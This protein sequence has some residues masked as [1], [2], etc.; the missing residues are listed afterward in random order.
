MNRDIW[1]ATGVAHSL[2]AASMAGPS[3]RRGFKASS[4]AVGRR[5]FASSHHR[6]VTHCTPLGDESGA[7][8]LD[9]RVP[10]TAAYK[11]QEQDAES[12]CSALGHGSGAHSPASL[13]GQTTGGHWYW[14]LTQLAVP[15]WHPTGMA[16]SLHG[17]GAQPDASVPPDEAQEQDT[18]SHCAPLGHGSGAHWAASLLGQTTGGH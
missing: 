15:S 11:T 10:P 2:H 13:L 8:L 5:R 17:R 6:E 14:P 12:Q 18:G 3:A 1:I 4:R 9:A 7:Q 16:G